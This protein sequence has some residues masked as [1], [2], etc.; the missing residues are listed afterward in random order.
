M[1]DN[2]DIL[3]YSWTNLINF[4]FATYRHLRIAQAKEKK[5]RLYTI[6]IKYL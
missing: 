3:G 6:Q 1:R 2:P 4:S 5:Y